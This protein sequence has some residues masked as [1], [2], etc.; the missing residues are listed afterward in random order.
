M[1]RRPP[2]STLFPY[3][4]LFRS[5]DAGRGRPRGTAVGRQWLAYHATRSR[6][7]APARGPGGTAPRSPL[8]RHRGGVG[9]GLRSPDTGG[10]AGRPARVAT[11]PHARP[12]VRRP[13]IR[14]SLA[15]CPLQ[16][17]KGGF[18]AYVCGSRS[19]A[20]AATVTPFGTVELTVYP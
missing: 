10:R 17:A 11:R 2:R 12:D 15:T 6:G 19:P 3:T 1:I 7:P 4:T 9:E 8:P 16:P 20:G 13:G 18:L 5:A 14:L